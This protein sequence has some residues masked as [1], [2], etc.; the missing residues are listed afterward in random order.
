MKTVVMTAPGGP[1]TLEVRDL[2][3]PALQSPRDVK[4]RLH[5]AG[6]NPV[7]TKLRARGLM[8][9][10]A[11]FPA[12]LGC[13]GAG[14]VVE[15]GDAVT[16][17]KPGDRV[18]CC[19][20]GLGGDQ[21]CY[22]EFKVL[23]E[24]SA[25]TLPASMDFIHAAAGPLV[26]IT[27]WEALF[28]RARLQAR[29]TVLI[30]G[31][32]GGVGHVAVQLAT[33]AGARVIGTVSSNDKAAFVRALGAE[34]CINYQQTDFVAAVNDWTGGEGVAIALDTVGGETFTRTIDCVAHYGDLVTILAP[35]A[36]IDWKEARTRN[37]RI[38]FELMLT[39]MLRDL[40]AARA[41]HGEI[42]DRCAEWIDAGRLKIEVAQTLP[43]AQAVEAHRLIEAGGM[44]GKVVLEIP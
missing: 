3:E 11:G 16:R 42:L 33:I 15:V 13:D 41:H 22:A 34:A 21:G 4:V 7:D 36:D 20:G 9:P 19:D 37:L 38:G 23:D 12:V 24:S 25:R 43:L 35:D 18:W 5:A 27:A 2:P 44:R 26:L 28:D 17:L 6:I 39:P 10:G 1:E 32:A 8:V 31:A 30:H 14:E 29:Q 40:P